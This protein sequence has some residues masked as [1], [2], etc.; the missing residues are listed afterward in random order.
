M[1]KRLEGLE[2]ERK[3]LELRVQETDDVSF[4]NVRIHE[5]TWQST[6]ALYTELE[7]LSKAWEVLEQQNRSK[8]FDLKDA[9]LKVSRLTTEVRSLDY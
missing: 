2:A 8:V 7:Q 9:E 4:S 5:L 6:N 3:K 1:A